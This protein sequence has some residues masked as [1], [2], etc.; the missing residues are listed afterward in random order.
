MGK[1]G[2][3]KK[4]S[5]ERSQE[6]YDNYSQRPYQVSRSPPRRNDY[7]NQVCYFSNFSNLI[8]F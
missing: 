2:L 5:Q 3:M 4:R 6:R 1:Q 8:F 7:D